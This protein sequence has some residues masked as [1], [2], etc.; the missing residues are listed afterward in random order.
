[1]YKFAGGSYNEVWTYDSGYTT[2]V[3]IGDVD[4]DGKNELLSIGESHKSVLQH[5]GGYTYI[6]QNILDPSDK[7]RYDGA[8]IG[9]TDNDGMPEIVLLRTASGIEKATILEYASGVYGASWETTFGSGPNIFTRYDNCYVGDSDNN[10]QN[11]IVF[12]T[13]SGVYIYRYKH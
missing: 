3:G 9:D 2:R 10:G 5:Q 4:N 8:S 7:D 6:E 12:S 13:D 1:M 11:E